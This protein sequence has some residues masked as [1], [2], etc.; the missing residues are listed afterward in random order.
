MTVQDITPE[1]AKHFNFSETEGVFVTDVEPESNADEAGIKRGDVIL[2]VNKEKISNIKEFR[3][4][5]RSGKKRDTALFLISRDNR[6]LFIA[7]R[8]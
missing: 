8:K 1:L 5:I 4:A 3:K 2:D 6:I 7:V